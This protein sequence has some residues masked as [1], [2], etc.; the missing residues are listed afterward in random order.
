MTLVINSLRGRD[1]YTHS[2]QKHFQETRC[3]P[4]LKIRVFKMPHGYL[5]VHAQ[6]NITP[7]QLHLTYWICW[8][9]QNIREMFFINNYVGLQGVGT[10]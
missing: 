6:D 8:T 7:Q 9:S 1:T 10:Q 4:G 5:E 2:V 3:T